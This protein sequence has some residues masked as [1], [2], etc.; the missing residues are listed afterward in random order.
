MLKKIF[1]MR[2]G[3]KL[4]VT[5][6]GDLS[7]H[8][9]FFFHG[10]IG[11]HY[12]AS[13][14]ADQARQERLRIIAP[15]RPGV[16]SSELTERSS[17]L[18]TAG[19]VEEIAEAL[20]LDDFSLI[21]I[22]GG[23][24]YSLAALFRHAPRVRAVALISGLGPMRLPGAL[25]GMDLRRRAILETGSR[26]AYLS[27]RFFQKASASFRSDPERFLARLIATWSA[28]DRKL[29][30]RRA[31]YDLFM[32]DLHEVFTK[33]KGPESLSQELRL[34]RSPGFSLR[35]LPA[36]KR[37]TLWHGLSDNIVPPAMTW[38]LAQT[39]SNCEAHFV[40]GGHFVA[41]DVAG[42]IIS[43]FKQLLDDPAPVATTAGRASP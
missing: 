14:I 4:E 10:L 20:Q 13:Y 6:Y 37:I 25:Q 29:F 17:A 30:E 32:R 38:K 41:I 28:P 35:D 34:Y 21:G 31:I 23:A 18:E 19:D 33:G 3:R 5:E 42:Q 39:L 1:V 15:N 26:Y 9:T 43:R 27:T 7:G 11:S 16:G 12:Q 40:P 2:S 24:P 36:D 22:S 8:P